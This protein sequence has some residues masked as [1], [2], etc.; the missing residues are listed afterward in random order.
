MPVIPVMQRVMLL[1][2]SMR[3]KRVFQPD[4]GDHSNGWQNFI[5]KN[6]M[7]VL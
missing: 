3:K 2:N 5:A 7:F 6:S 1:I 4:K